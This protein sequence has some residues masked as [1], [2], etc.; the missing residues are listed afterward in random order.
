MQTHCSLHNYTYQV[1][2]NKYHIQTKDTRIFQ[3]N[4]LG[5]TQCE[6]TVAV[7]L[8]SFIIIQN[9][10]T[11]FWAPKMV[12]PIDKIHGNCTLSLRDRKYR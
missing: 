7:A 12:F 9:L 1:L 3:T 10:N 2:K 11:T 4:V 6:K 5:K 8:E